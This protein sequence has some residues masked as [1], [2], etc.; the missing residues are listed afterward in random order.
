MAKIYCG[1]RSLLP[2]SADVLARLRDLDDDYTVLLEFDVPNANIDCIILK[3]SPDGRPSTFILT[4]IKHVSGRL[5]GME[6]TAWYVTRNGIETPL[7]ASN[8][9]DLNPWQQT[10]RALNAFREWFRVNQTVF[11]DRP[12]ILEVGEVKVWPMLLVVWRDQPE[13][14]RHALPIHP[15]SRFGSFAFSLDQ[16]IRFVE[17]WKPTQGIA[18][19]QGDITRIV[20]ALHLNPVLPE[21]IDHLAAEAGIAMPVSTPTSP[22][23]ASGVTPAAILPWAEA[24]VTW[25]AAVEDRLARIEAQLSL[26]SEAS[27]SRTPIDPP[28]PVERPTPQRRILSDE[29]REALILAVG[30]A[31]RS[32][33]RMF[34]EVLSALNVRLGYDLKGRHF[35]GFL[36][37]KPF[38]DQAVEE[39]I[40]RYGPLAGPAPTVYL[41]DEWIPAATTEANASAELATTRRQP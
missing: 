39:G 1:N 3:A 30:D 25:A 4:E 32:G 19:T 40:I 5:R 35:N 12:A 23:A 6:N 33:R 28:S 13:N 20:E 24:F 14:Q 16:W 10:L 27:P 9:D 31:A 26:A 36:R 17:Q 18:I 8:G 22:L 7:S 41:P 2:P 38:L 37:L 15:S 34:P 11:L 21:E 29:E